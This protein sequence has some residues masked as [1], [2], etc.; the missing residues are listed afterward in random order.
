M[1]NRQVMKRFEERKELIKK[2][3]QEVRSLPWRPM[4][5]EEKV[6]D[7]SNG[8]NGTGNAGN[9][10]PQ[11]QEHRNGTAAEGTDEEGVFL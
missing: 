3:V 6:P 1:E 11:Q 5:E 10:G 7:V 8:T 9:G 4:G 2:E